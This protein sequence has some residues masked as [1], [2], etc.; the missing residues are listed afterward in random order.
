[1]ASSA[2]CLGAA[3]I[4]RLWAVTAVGP[5]NAT[6]RIRHLVITG[7]NFPIG[8]TYVSS[9]YSIPQIRDSSPGSV[10]GAV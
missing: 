6:N 7:K 10:D 2:V 4:S 3:A 8:F 5:P 1:V 9:M